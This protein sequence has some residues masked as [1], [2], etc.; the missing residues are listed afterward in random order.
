MCMAC[1]MDDELWFAYLDQMARQ[2][3]AVAEVADPAGGPPSDV[4]PA[5]KPALAS[6]FVCE[7]PPSE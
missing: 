5:K 1:Q 4:G 7:E 6:P 3:K 2:E